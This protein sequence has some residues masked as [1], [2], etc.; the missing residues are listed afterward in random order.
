[1]TDCISCAK[2]VCG[3]C[4]LNK[5]CALCSQIRMNR[6]TL[7]KSYAIFQQG[8]KMIE[9]N[10]GEEAFELLTQSIILSP[11]ESIY[12]NFRGMAAD[13]MRI[14]SLE[15]KD[16]GSALQ[17]DPTLHVVVGNRMGVY[18][19]LGDFENAKKDGETV[20]ELL[21]QADDFPHC[22]SR[23]RALEALDRWEDA[24]KELDEG[25]V[26]WKDNE[27]VFQLY[28]ERALLFSRW[29][30][31]LDASLLDCDNALGCSNVTIYWSSFVYHKKSAIMCELQKFEMAQTY[32]EESIKRGISPQIMHHRQSIIFYGMGLREDCLRHWSFLTDET[33][34]MW[35]IRQIKVLNLIRKN[36]SAINALSIMMEIQPNIFWDTN[37][38]HLFNKEFQQMTLSFCMIIK[39]LKVK[40]RMFITKQIFY[41]I[42]RTTCL[43][44]LCEGNICRSF[45]KVNLSF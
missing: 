4:S 13:I 24:I 32:L 34:N 45:N 15:I 1:M 17:I 42:I 39:I 37:L 36:S 41:K 9:L 11:S 7:N 19:D 2:K 6:T 27:F 3:D 25:I 14:F 20:L 18:S 8:K 44:L 23:T 16:L 28:Y 40:N 22:L 26:K 12:Y 10:K 35:V 30:E 38:H 43:I 21:P 29:T 33:K 31:D 5:K